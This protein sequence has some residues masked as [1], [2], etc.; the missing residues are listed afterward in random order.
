MKYGH[1]YTEFEF[2]PNDWFGFIYRIIELHTGR[3]YIGKK[4]FTKLRRKKLKGRKNRKHVITESDWKKYTGSSE[5]LNLAIEQNGIDN[6]LFIIESLHKTRGSLH[7]AEVR[8][9]VFEDVLRKTMADGKTKWYY[10]KN[11][12]SIKFLPPLERDDESLH[13]MKKSWI[14]LTTDEKEEWCKKQLV[15]NLNLKPYFVMLAHNPTKKM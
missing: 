6:Y 14:Y 2:N 9:H 5:H 13:K 11:I 15:D 4:K 7:Y 8:Y 1:W 3:E 10:N 12:S